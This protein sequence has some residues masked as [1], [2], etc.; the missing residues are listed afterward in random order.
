MDALPKTIL[1]MGATGRQGAAVVDALLSRS[2]AAWRIICLT[3]EPGSP[4]ARALAAR[5]L[6]LA[7]CDANSRASLDA[8][9]AAHAPVHAFFC[10]T[11]PFAARWTGGAA[12]R[13][14]T[15]AEAQQGIHAVDACKAAA[16]AHF[17]FTSVASANDC[18]V[19][20]E[21]VETFAAKW[22]VEEH[23]RASGLPHTIL[24]PCG[25]FENLQSPFAGLKQGVV[26][27]LLRTASMQMISCKDI[28]VFAAIALENREAWLGRRFEL[29]GD[30]TS[31]EKQAAALSAL[32]G[33]EP[34][35]V[36]VPPDWVR[37]PFFCCSGARLRVPDLPPLPPFRRCSNCSSRRRWEN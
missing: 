9:L 22:R 12:P 16:V 20:G 18:T 30:A 6:A 17:V 4:P 23:L 35:R 10:V 15:S 24:A 36:K 29:A 33:G 8:A 2:P 37:P 27:G 14:D 28:G 31:A 13:G 7:R 11:N 1:V 26:P 19:D 32:R 34:W 3:R 21:P 25:F 5:G